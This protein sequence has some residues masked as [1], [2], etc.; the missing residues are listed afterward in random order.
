M[1]TTA[2]ELSLYKAARDK[3][4]L[5]GQSYQIGDNKFTRADLATIEKTIK[6]LEARIVLENSNHSG[7]INLV[8]FG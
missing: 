8:R 1:A 7:F 5:G 2:E 6:D 4:L 3:I